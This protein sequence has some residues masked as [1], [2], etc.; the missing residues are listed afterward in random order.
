MAL[1][2]DGHIVLEAKDDAALLQ[3]LSQVFRGPNPDSSDAVVICG[4]QPSGK[5]GLSVMR[6]MR[7][8][9]WCPPFILMTAF[10]DDEFRTRA[11]RLGA[12][13]IFGKPFDLDTLLATVGSMAAGLT[14]TSV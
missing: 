5:D 1:R 12:H 7:Q 14:M 8:Y 13:A 4:V 11:W 2:R 9:P 3:D 6:S 10:A